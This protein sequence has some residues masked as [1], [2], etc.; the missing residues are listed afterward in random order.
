MFLLQYFH[1]FSIPFPSGLSGYFP[2][3]PTTRLAAFRLHRAARQKAEKEKLEETNSEREK[4]HL[5][6]DC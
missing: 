4:E 6:P 2:I 3:H 5:G 1:L